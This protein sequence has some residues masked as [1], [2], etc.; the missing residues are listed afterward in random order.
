LQI[1]LDGN[2]KNNM[3]DKTTIEVAK[4]GPIVVCNLAKITEST[5]SQQSLQKK[6]SLLSGVGNQRQNL[7]VTV[8]TA[9]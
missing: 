8:L 6:L 7:F 4:N 1:I 2:M 3:K 5:G 9:R